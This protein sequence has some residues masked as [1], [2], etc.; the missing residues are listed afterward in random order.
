[1]GETKKKKEEASVTLW[2]HFEGGIL[3]SPHTAGCG[4]MPLSSEARGPEGRRKRGAVRKNGREP[5]VGRLESV[6]E[7]AGRT[8]GGALGRGAGELTV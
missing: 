8:G 1:M 4:K 5:F 7:G 2:R 6:R 3:V